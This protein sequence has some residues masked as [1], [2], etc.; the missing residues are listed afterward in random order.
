[1]NDTTN[2][3]PQP[4]TENQRWRWLHRELKALTKLVEDTKDETSYTACGVSDLETSV[5]N[6][7]D[8]LE[9]NIG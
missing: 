7:L 9:K 2:E 6:R 4:I 8:E 5:R 3:I 1:M